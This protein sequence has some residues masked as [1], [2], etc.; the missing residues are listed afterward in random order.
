MPASSA[1]KAKYN[2]LVVGCGAIG[3]GYDLN[4]AA[5]LT[6]AK[7]FHRH[8]RTTLTV[9]DADIERARM[10]ANVYGAELIEDL[11]PERMKTFDI[12]SVCVP[13][14]GH[15]DILKKALQ[16]E[17]PLI[18]CEKPVVATVD[19]V[20]ALRSL[21][22]E[23]RHCIMVN[24]IRRYQPGYQL[25]KHRLGEILG[26]DVLHHIAIRYQRGFLNNCGH[27]LD[28]L[29]FL[30][31]HPVLSGPFQV[32]SHVYDAFPSDPTLSGMFVFKNTPVSVTGFSQTAS[33]VFEID[34]FTSRWRIEV[35]DSG[36]TIR[37]H[38]LGTAGRFEEV[39][40]WH[41][42]DVIKDYMIPVAEEALRLLDE[43]GS[44]HFSTALD[45]N[46]AMLNI[47][48]SD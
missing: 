1:N 39:P 12:I 14:S 36:N 40:A 19:E 32:A 28:L 7:A 26:I 9:A 47:I 34:F 35:R 41:Q 43:T 29:E 23:D 13:T 4:S 42:A 15:F 30:L 2:A 16:A 17:V 33:P 3:A 48:H 21:Y 37:Y 25:L 31:G 44:T 5:V 45:L 46:E 18:L 24:Y 27:A 10:V 22:H 20:S 6:H 38:S 11:S 8:P